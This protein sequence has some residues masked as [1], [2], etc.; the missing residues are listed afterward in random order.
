M[1]VSLFW[2]VYVLRGRFFMHHLTIFSLAYGGLSGTV[3]A[4]GGTASESSMQKRCVRPAALL[5]AW[6]PP[7]G[8]A[9]GVV[10]ERNVGAVISVPH[11][12]EPETAPRLQLPALVQ[13]LP[14]LRLRECARLYAFFFFC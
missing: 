9:V 8:A 2:Y 12:Q 1:F 10:S 6:L 4:A 13:P 3:G 7:P 5:P 14:L 11:W